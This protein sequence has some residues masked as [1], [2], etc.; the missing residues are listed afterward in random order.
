MKLLKSEACLPASDR[1]NVKR[2][3]A[4]G[5]AQVLLLS[6]RGSTPLASTNETLDRCRGLFASIKVFIT[7]IGIENTILF[8][9]IIIY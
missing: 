7:N 5:D 2:K 1:G 4:L 3:T 8:I 9:N 6:D